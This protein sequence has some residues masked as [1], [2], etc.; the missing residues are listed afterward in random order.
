MT[1]IKCD[2]TSEIEL[3]LKY[4]LDEVNNNLNIGLKKIVHNISKKITDYDDTFHSIIMLPAFKN[5]VE[6]M[7]S[8]NA[9]SSQS[10]SVNPELL[11]NYEKLKS[12]NE[13]LK[14]EILEYQKIIKN[15]NREFDALNN[16]VFKLKDEIVKLNEKNKNEEH[17]SLKIEET[18]A[19][20]STSVSEDTGK[21][22][23]YTK[24]L[25]TDSS[26]IESEE[27]EEVEELEETEELEEAEEAEE[28]EE[29]D[30]EEV[31]VEVEEEEDVE[32][33]EVE[34]EE[35]VEEVE[36]VE[37]V[38]KVEV[39]EEEE[40]VEETEEEEVFEIEID[41]IL[42]FT[43]DDENGEIYKIDS[44]GNPGDVVGNFKDGEP[45]FL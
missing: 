44:D 31:E 12:D 24:L 33:V 2:S 26:N 10:A 32:E 25:T 27:E 20:I 37:E 28:V 7:Q 8:N 18:I 41:D 40:D 35:D 14:N 39:E 36:E 19:E 29:E 5:Y 16:V 23:I 45:I 1:I 15:K 4:L 22:P 42:Y 13:K 34:E 17:I 9:D 6:K 30:V 43:N 3:D 38:E 11:Y 21:N